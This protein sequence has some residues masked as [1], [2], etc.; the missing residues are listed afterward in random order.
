MIEIELLAFNET[1]EKTNLT[2]TRSINPDIS[3]P[4]LAAFFFG[5]RAT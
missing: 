5:V 2:K 1:D 3:L 4:L